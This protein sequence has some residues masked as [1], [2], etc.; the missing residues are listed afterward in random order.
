MHDRRSF[1]IVLAV[2]ICL[3][4]LA[5]VGTGAETRQ[6][7]A[8]A[9]KPATVL[10]RQHTESVEAWRKRVALLGH[11]WSANWEQVSQ[12]ANREGLRSPK[13]INAF[14]GMIVRFSGTLGVRGH[15]YW[16]VDTGLRRGCKVQFDGPAPPIASLGG[17]RITVEVVALFHT[18]VS[19]GG[20]HLLLR[21]PILLRL[22]PQDDSTGK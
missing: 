1:N 4:M 12:M 8:G 13:E 7:T 18:I 10:A 19:K 17:T 15:T 22:Q 9:P 11:E 16:R 6:K 2:W 5:R 20:N 14:R 21:H 3:A